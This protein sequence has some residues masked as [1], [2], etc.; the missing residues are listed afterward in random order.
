MDNQSKGHF[1]RIDNSRWEMF[2]IPARPD[3]LLPRGA[4]VTTGPSC[5]VWVTRFAGAP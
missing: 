4:G 3:P 1:S 2:R 5:S